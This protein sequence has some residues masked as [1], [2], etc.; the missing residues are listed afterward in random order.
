M[1][2]VMVSFLF[3]L[4][5]YI[6]SL[7]AHIHHHTYTGGYTIRAY[8]FSYLSISMASLPVSCSPLYTLALPCVVHWLSLS[9]C[10][11][12]TSWRV[13]TSLTCTIHTICFSPNFLFSFPLHPPLLYK[14]F[15]IH[16]LFSLTHAQ[17]LS[18][19]NGQQ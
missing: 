7:I 18:L 16:F 3:I 1:R 9:S 14:I 2:G 17:V 11:A 6:L 4:V 10:E 13:K 15:T 19:L 5:S 8:T 12:S